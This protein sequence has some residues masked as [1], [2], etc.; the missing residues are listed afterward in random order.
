[1]RARALTFVVT[2]VVVSLVAGL[3]HAELKLATL[4]VKGMV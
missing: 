2:L 3:A 1:M 4:I